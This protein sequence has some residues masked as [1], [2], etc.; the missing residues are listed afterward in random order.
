MTHVPFLSN[1]ESASYPAKITWIG[2]E[3]TAT[4]STFWNLTIKRDA[5]IGKALQIFFG[6]FWPAL[7]EVGTLGFI[8]EVIADNK[9]AVQFSLKI[10]QTVAVGDFLFLYYTELSTFHVL[11]R[12]WD[13]VAILRGR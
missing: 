2:K 8:A 4:I 6:G 12:L 3:L 9:F 7:F 11:N 5:S 13:C 10:D 1:E